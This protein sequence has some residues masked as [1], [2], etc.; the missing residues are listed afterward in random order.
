MRRLYRQG[1]TTCSGGNIS[2]RCHNGHILITPS[3]LDKGIINARQIALM[4]PEGENYT[5]GLKPSIETDMHLKILKSRPDTRAVVHAHPLHASLLTAAERHIPTDILAEARFLL[6]ET[7]FVPYAL[8]GTDDLATLTAE[9]AAKGAAA[10]MLENHGV[11]TVG[12]TLLQAFDRME[13]LEAAA[14]MYVKA[15]PSL[16]LHSLDDGRL[17][18]IDAMHTN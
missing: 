14:A 1:L 9:A 15:S 3:A 17:N 2:Y 16:K 13:V 10:L 12:N 11:L 8:M 18:D 6:G 7:V 5:T 4:T